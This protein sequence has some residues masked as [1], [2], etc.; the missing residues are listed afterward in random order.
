MILKD[1]AVPGHHL[2]CNCEGQGHSTTK[3]YN[4]LSGTT[5][6][7]SGTTSRHLMPNRSPPD[8]FLLRPR[9]FEGAGLG[10]GAPFSPLVQRSPLELIP[11][12]TDVR[13]GQGGQSGQDRRRLERDTRGQ[14]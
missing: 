6:K 2:K 11:W 13:S 10:R 1:H 12:Y 5:T 4:Q 14:D 8:L 9:V 3:H 7:L